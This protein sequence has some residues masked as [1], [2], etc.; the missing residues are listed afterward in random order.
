MKIRNK[1]PEETYKPKHKASSAHRSELCHRVLPV[2]FVVCC[3]LTPHSKGE[4][5]SE[6]CD[7]I[8]VLE[9]YLPEGLSDPNAPQI[10]ENER[11]LTA[12][13][14]DQLWKA[15]VALP[16]TDKGVQTNKSLWE[17]MAQVR[18]VQFKQEKTVFEPIVVA[19]PAKETEPNENIL[20]S[21]APKE[22]VIDVIEPERPAA[23][24]TPGT[25]QILGELSRNPEKIEDPFRLAEILF[26][27][28]NV[29]EAAAFYREALNRIEVN[30]V[31][32]ADNRAWIQFQIG[33]CLRDDSPQQARAAYRQLIIEHPDS[34]W[35]EMAKAYE[36]LID[37]Y[38]QDEPLNLIGRHAFEG[39]AENSA[40]GANK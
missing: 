16:T 38:Q 17:I 20:S 33:N 29:K 26:L 24:I 19:E 7:P 39:P 22:P 15:R 13:L 35:T 30:D 27:S 32:S 40:P 31:W 3:F 34:P 1:K 18:S 2:V 21:E 14:A 5:T 36:E 6:Q 12:N 25:L 11:S 4:V 10:Q 28:R 23:K 37:W 8:Y 9:K